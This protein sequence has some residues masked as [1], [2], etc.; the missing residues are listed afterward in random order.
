MTEDVWD[1]DLGA[2]SV[3]RRFGVNF[4]RV[5]QL[6]FRDYRR[7]ECPLHAS[8]LT[9]NSIMSI[10]PIL[11]LSLALA[12]GLGGEDAAKEW[13]RNRVGD[14]THSF[15]QT[16]A[17]V[18][19]HLAQ[20]EGVSPGADQAAYDAAALARQ[21]NSLVETG[22]EKMGN[23]NFGA[24]GGVGLAVLIWMVIAVLGQVESSFNGV[25]GVTVQRPLWRKFTDYISILFILPLLLLAASSLPIADLASRHLDDTSARMVRD[26]L[27]SGI[28]KHVMVFTMTSAAFTFLL[29]FMPNTK[30][31][32]VPGASGGVLTAICFLVWMWICAALQVGAVRAGKIYGSFA[33]FPILLAWVNVSWQI[34][35]FGAE[36][37]FAIQNCSTYRMEQG[38]SRASVRARL[39]LALS[40]VVDAAHGML[41][42]DGRPFQVGEFVQARRIPMRFLLATLDD[43]VKAGLMA[44]V[45]GV[46]GRYALLRAPDTVRV[47]DV[48]DSILASGVAPGSLG[49]A[50]V[51]ESVTAVVD[52]MAKGMNDALA[53][54]TVRDVVGHMGRE[55]SIP[56]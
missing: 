19:R 26:V 13:V 37:A 2:L 4:I 47:K 6:V 40:V 8:A 51:P 48:F 18:D 28:L 43:L 36:V 17:A 50:R 34:I 23:V 41:Q 21:I 15:A 32:F 25:W 55:S 5:V 20:F 3:R 54:R 53:N 35:L 7:D 10:V 52:Q 44:E 33:T 22:F 29:M 16:E 1:L 9:F 42:P 27:G 46:P 56:S 11:A 49:L 31:R 24:L 38:A 14:W 39:T 12:R 30:V 45:A